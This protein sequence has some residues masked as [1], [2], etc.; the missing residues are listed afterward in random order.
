MKTSLN[1]L[2]EMLS[3]LILGG[4][5]EVSVEFMGG[6]T[7]VGWQFPGKAGDCMPLEVEWEE[8]CRLSGSSC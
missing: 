7:I 6:L 1:E 3:R 2:A 8:S 5:T 4:A